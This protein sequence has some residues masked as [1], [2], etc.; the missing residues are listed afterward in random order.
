MKKPFY[1]LLKTRGDNYMYDVNRNVIIKIAE[2]V[3]KL[4]NA[5]QENTLE[6]DDINLKQGDEY[7]TIRK[8]I[9]DGFLSTDRAKEI[10]HPADDVLVY[11]IDNKISMLTLQVTQ[12]CN[13]RCRYCVFSG[14][15]ENRGHSNRSMDFKTAKKGIDFLIGHSAE[16][17]RISLGFYGG[18][19]LLE[20]DLIRK[21]IEYSE[22]KAEGKEIQ[23]TLTT[24]GTILEEKMIE[25][26]EKH[27]MSLVISLDGPSEIHNKNRRFSLDNRGSFEVM[28]DRLGKIKSVFPE[29]FKKITFNAVLDQENDFGCMNKFFTEYETICESEVHFSFLAEQYRKSNIKYSENFD[30]KVGY[31]YFKILLSKTGRLDKRYY[32]KLVKQMFERNHIIYKQLVPFEKV[33]EISHPS[34]PCIPGARRLFMDVHGGFFP[35]ERVSECSEVMK[36]GHVDSGIDI[37]KVRKIL[38]I[39]KITEEKCKNCWAFRFCT[40]CAAA[41]DNTEDLSAEKKVEQCYNVSF[42]A[43]ETLKNICTLSEFGVDLIDDYEAEYFANA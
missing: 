27:D 39:G 35:C 37:G 33:S 41:A 2:N 13:L 11:F 16:N 10:R 36:I 22:E 8:M 19:P 7:E 42:S 26:F 32:S 25:Y 12:K 28:M 18:E 31:E 43:E 4:L 23:F 40:I 5:L 14:G 24:N 17:N 21:C 38:N 15:Y 34:G 29:Y 9:K 20:F 30:S 6:L 3:Y 1:H